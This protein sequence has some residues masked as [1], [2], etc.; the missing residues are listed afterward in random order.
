[1][2]FRLFGS[3]GVQALALMALSG[4]IVHAAQWST[5][6]GNNVRWN[7]SRADMYIST[8]SFPIGSTWDADLQNAMWHWN[9]V[10]GSAFDFYF[11]RDTDGNHNSSN[12]RNE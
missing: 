10:K 6:S 9:N 2:Q 5:C 8:T 11:G 7:G 12:G 3:I 4:S 1:M